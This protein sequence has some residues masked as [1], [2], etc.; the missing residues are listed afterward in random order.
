MRGAL[1]PGNGNLSKP[2]IAIYFGFLMGLVI[3]A[4]AQIFAVSD[5]HGRAIRRGNRLLAHSTDAGW[6]PLYAALMEEAPF[7]ATEQGVRHPS[8]IYHVSRPTEVTRRIDSSK[9]ERALIG[10]RCITLTPGRP[11]AWWSHGGRPE[12]LQ[13]Y[14]HRDVFSAAAAEMFG[15][16]P[17]KADVSPRFAISDPLL[18]QLS[19]AVISALRD[20]DHSD[21][22]YVQSLA[23]MIAAHLARMHSNCSKPARTSAPAIANWKM[24]RL[25]EF[26]ES[27]L[28]QNL[29]LTA[30][31]QEIGIS[32]LYLPRAF[33]NAFGQ[34]AHQYVLS[35]RI[36][37]A[38]DLLRNAD[39]TV[40]EISAATGF[41]SQSHLSDWFSRNVGVTP[42]VYRRQNLG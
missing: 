9:P 13:V 17:E 3:P 6:G 33:K 11:S 31:A 8:F 5:T 15:C 30:L 24:R 20:G 16:D 21:T 40:A 22:L 39:L 12:I 36:E 42:A 14:V 35:R 26:I 37:R 18:E 27:N 4:P 7:E 32:P 38:K 1:A 25:K 2:E 23:Q 41:S 19:L 10:P 34:S 29:S 28:E